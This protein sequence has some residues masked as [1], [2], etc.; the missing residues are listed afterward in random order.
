LQSQFIVATWVVSCLNW[1]ESLNPLMGGCDYCCDG[2]LRNFLSSLSLPLI[3]PPC[4]RMTIIS[5]QL[6]PHTLAATAIEKSSL[7]VMW[8]SLIDPVYGSMN[9]SLLE[10]APV[11]G[12]VGCDCDIR[13]VVY[14]GKHHCSPISSSLEV[15]PPLHCPELP[16]H[17]NI[18]LHV[19]SHA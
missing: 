18:M 5:L 14:C 12:G 9:H 17:V 13:A 8:S 3:P 7:T 6:C 16:V 10:Y 11:A 4:F 19:V 15:M 1:I 2:G